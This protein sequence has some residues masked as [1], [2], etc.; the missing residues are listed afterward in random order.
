MDIST[1]VLY[2]LVALFGWGLS[3]FIARKAIDEEGHYRILFF[4]TLLG[5]AFLLVFTALF[6]KVPALSLEMLVVLVFLGTLWTFGCLA[7]YKAIEIGK[8]SIVSPVGASWAIIAVLIGFFF[9]SERVTPERGVGIM[10]AVLGIALASTSF[11]EL[12]KA[13]RAVLMKGVNYALFAM[14]GWGLMFSYLGPVI[15]SLG[16]VLP[17]L[18]LKVIAIAYLLLLSPIKKK[19]LALPTKKVALLVFFVAVLDV[20][21]FLGFNYGLQI[22]LISIVSPTSAAFPAVTVLLAYVF[23]KERVELNQKIGILAIIAGL[24]LMALI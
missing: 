1:G 7:F 19:S 23:L 24:V 4:S 9:F 10:L 22:E 18:Y 14:L 20:I 6:L 5:A 2:G 13:R 16:P 3:D 8:L 12:R 17:I 15:D 11:S 21:A